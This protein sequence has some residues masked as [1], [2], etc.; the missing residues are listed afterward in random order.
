MAVGLGAHDPALAIPGYALE[1]EFGGIRI[2]RRQ[3]DAP[4]ARLWQDYTPT[5]SGVEWIMIR[6]DPDTPVPP[7]NSGV[8]F[9]DEAA[10][11]TS[12]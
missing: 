12:P 7:S 8:R 3:A 11:G 10:P 4:A 1:R 2:L 9:I 6:V 5:I